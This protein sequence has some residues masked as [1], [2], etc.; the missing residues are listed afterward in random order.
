MKI[1][2][3]LFIVNPIDFLN[4][5]GG[6]TGFVNRSEYMD[7]TWIYLGETEI[8]SYV[9]LEF[10]QTAAIDG[11]DKAIKQ[12]KDEHAAKLAMLEEQRGKLLCIDHTEE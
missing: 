6:V 12:Q 2:L 3:H 11:I 1:K 9:S 7:D 4:N 8:E 5:G 10:I